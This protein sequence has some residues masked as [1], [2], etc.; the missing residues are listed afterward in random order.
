ME[1]YN[2]RSKSNHNPKQQRAS[3]VREDTDSRAARLCEARLTV[4]CQ[5]TGGRLDPAR[6]SRT[7]T[8]YCRGC[9]YRLKLNR[10]AAYKRRKRREMGWRAYYY[11]YAQFPTG[12][13]LEAERKAEHRDD[14]RAR[15][16]YA[17]H[18]REVNLSLTKAE[19]RVYRRDFINALTSAPQGDQRPPAARAETTQGE[20]GSADIKGCAV[21]LFSISRSA[22]QPRQPMNGGTTR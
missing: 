9:A 6:A 19:E 5:R 2:L 17:K 1:S 22:S 18:C 14:M 7:T 16:A 12:V 3:V 11:E 10:N 4:E 15:R 20:A 8:R 13:D 21:A